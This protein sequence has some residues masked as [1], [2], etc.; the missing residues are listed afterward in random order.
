MYENFFG[1]QQRPFL[2]TARADRYHANPAAENVR[3]P[4][5]RCVERSE[6]VGTLIAAAGLGKSMLCRLLAEQLRAKYLVA[7]VLGGQIGS[8]RMLYQ[9]LLYEVGQ[10][11]R[12]LD[13][14]ELRLSLLGYLENSRAPMV[15]IVDEAHA[16][17]PRVLEELRALCAMLGGTETQPRLIMAGTPALE[18]RLTHPKLVSLSQ[19]IVVRCY[20]ERLSRSDVAEYVRAELSLAGAN[21]GSVF[22]E[23]AYEAVFRAT[24]GIPRLINQVCDH[25]LLLARAAGQHLVHC[26]IIEEA[27]ADLQQLPLPQPARGVNTQSAMIEFATLADADDLP[28]SIPFPSTAASVK[29]RLDEVEAH[30]ANLANDF[31]PGGS[32]GPEVELVFDPNWNPFGEQFVEEEVVPD[33]FAATA[34]AAKV[35]LK[36][37]PQP[38]I[39]KSPAP[40]PQMVASSPPKTILAPVAVQTTTSR[41]EAQMTFASE[42]AVAMAPGAAFYV[43]HLGSSNITM[44]NVTVDVVLPDADPIVFETP[45]T[46]ASGRKPAIDVVE[47]EEPELIVIEEDRPPTVRTPSQR[48]IRHGEFRRLF[49]TM[50]RG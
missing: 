25:A 35:E 39:E 22:A 7:L 23:D 28:P 13:E 37:T 36:P 19:R 27:W 10:P 43:S 32:P 6:G 5:L 9:A 4:L 31:C 30:V 41:L 18:E 20:L 16:V 14:G 45:S 33:P 46:A 34:P 12:G 48:V 26:G 11:F 29:A 1:F 8:P 40:Q 44:P 50:K 38:A 49:A 47:P 21:P 24:D 2:A 17:S 15:V 3:T 42:T